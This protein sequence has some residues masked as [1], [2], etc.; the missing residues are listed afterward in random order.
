VFHKQKKSKRINKLDLGYFEKI[1]QVVT[2]YND[3]IRPPVAQV[4]IKEGGTGP[5]AGKAFFVLQ[6]K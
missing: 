3:G 5:N 6:C 1:Y 4:Y 2:G